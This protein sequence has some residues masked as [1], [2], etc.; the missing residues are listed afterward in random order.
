MK[1]LYLLCLETQCAADKRQPRSACHSCK[2]RGFGCRGLVPSTGEGPCA[3]SSQAP[4]RS[5]LEQTSHN[6]ALKLSHNA[7]LELRACAGSC[8]KEPPGPGQDLPSLLAVLLS[9]HMACCPP[10]P[11]APSAH[12][13]LHHTTT[14]PTILPP[15]NFAPPAAHVAYS[16]TSFLFFHC[17]FA[18]HPPHPR[19]GRFQPAS[20]RAPRAHEPSLC[21][22]NPILHY[23]TT[24]HRACSHA[25]Q[26]RCTHS[27]SLSRHFTV[28]GQAC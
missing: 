27:P 18:W 2:A 21:A 8:A 10:W 11:I 7:T 25:P 17:S 23:T 14:P 5:R 16:C 15:Q 3:R 12:H 20:L 4:H 22:Q 19:S 26:S 9:H 1:L 6:A 28:P 24:H 13:A